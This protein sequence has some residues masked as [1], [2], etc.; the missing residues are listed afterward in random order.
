VAVSD[1]LANVQPPPAP[2]ERGNLRAAKHGALSEALVSPRA[3]ELVP[4][5]FE[6]NPHLDGLRDHAA[7]VRYAVLLARIERVYAWLAAQKDEVFADARK[8]R[9]HRVFDRLERWERAAAS[10]EDALAIAP[11]P[12]AKLGLDRARGE[13]LLEHLR[14]HYGEEEK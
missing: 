9:T 6:A 14:K 3:E 7:V 5:V 10:A 13:E 2:A 12:R 11:G 8:G 4:E 1:G